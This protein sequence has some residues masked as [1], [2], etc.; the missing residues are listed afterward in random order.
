MFRTPDAERIQA[1]KEICGSIHEQNEKQLDCSLYVKT[2]VTVIT[3]DK[4]SDLRKLKTKWAYNKYDTKLNIYYSMW[5]SYYFYY[6]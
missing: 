2:L 5:S 3:I 6:L 1:E 4:L